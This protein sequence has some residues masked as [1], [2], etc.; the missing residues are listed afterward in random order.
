MKR[1]SL[2]AALAVATLAF[3]AA[4]ADSAPLSPPLAGAPASASQAPEQVMDGEIIVRLADNVDASAVAQDNGLVLAQAMR[5]ARFFVLRGDAGTERARAR[6]LLRDNRV[7][8]AEPNY[9]RKPPTINP[10]LG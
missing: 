8:Y 4:C 1:I 2:K 6:L 3:L 7:L 9:L 5:P 10:K